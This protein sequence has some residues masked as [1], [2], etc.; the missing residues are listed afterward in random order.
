[1]DLPSIDKNKHKG[2]PKET[3]D[4]SEVCKYREF[5]CIYAAPQL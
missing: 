5:I 1:M 3:L 4:N 2:K